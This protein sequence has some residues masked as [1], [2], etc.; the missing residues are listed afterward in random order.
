V[1]EVAGRVGMGGVAEIEDGHPKGMADVF[2]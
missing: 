2:I 1:V